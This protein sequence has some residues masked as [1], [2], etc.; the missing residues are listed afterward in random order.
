MLNAT[1]G[2]NH[3]EAVVPLAGAGGVAAAQ[4]QVLRIA[5]EWAGVETARVELVANIFH[6]IR[7]V[8]ASVPH[9][10]HS[11]HSAPSLGA[12]LTLRTTAHRVCVA[13]R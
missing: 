8:M 9:A 6:P 4:E 7:S 1:G 11:P 13:H 12:P 5:S 3:T 10:V 2:R